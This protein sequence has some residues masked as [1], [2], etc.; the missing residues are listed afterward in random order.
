M[1][2]K[3]DHLDKIIKYNISKKES[4]EKQLLEIYTLINDNYISRDEFV[5]LMTHI[6]MWRK[7]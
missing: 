2:F 1:N 5:F 7:V 3:T 4:L 6:E